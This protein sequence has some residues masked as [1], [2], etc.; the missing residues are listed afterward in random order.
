MVRGNRQPSAR[1]RQAPPGSAVGPC[2]QGGYRRR[3]RRSRRRRADREGRRRLHRF[4]RRRRDRP[5]GKV[6]RSGQVFSAP[7]AFMPNPE[8]GTV[9]MD[10]AKAVSTSSAAGSSSGQERQP[11]LRRLVQGV[12]HPEQFVENRGGPGGGPSPRFH[13]VEGPPTCLGASVAD[14]MGLAFRST[15]ARPAISRRKTC[16]DCRRRPRQPRWLAR[17]SLILWLCDDGAYIL[18]RGPGARNAEK[19]RKTGNERGRRRV[20]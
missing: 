13:D 4:R 1:H 5:R 15:R 17:F 10:V 14:T 6:G 3:G 18:P 20:C 19:F 2:A 7:A 9:T 12:F 11:F 16:P 8:A